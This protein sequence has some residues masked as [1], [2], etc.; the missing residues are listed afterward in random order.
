MTTFLLIRHGAH[1]LGG[2]TIA[3][4]MP[5]VRL[6]PLGHEQARRMAERVAKLPV[7]AIYSSPSD[8]TRETAVHLSEQLRRPVQVLE[9]LHEI[10]FG[11]WTGRNLDELRRSEHFRLWNAFRSGTRI[12]DG[13]AMIETQARIVC[14]MLRLRDKHPNAC[15]ALVSHGDV[16]KAAVAYFLGMPLDLFTRIEIGLAS[17]STIAIGEQGPWVLGVN[18]LGEDLVIPDQL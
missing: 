15:I 9:D 1:L 10:D 7:Q 18:N 5:E 3:G 6:S 13:E 12:P 4:R 16:I 14:A 8:R 11:S 2:D 17:V